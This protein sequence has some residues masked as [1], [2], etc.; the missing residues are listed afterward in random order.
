[1]AD[2]QAE[3]RARIILEVRS[4]RMT[5]E[6]G[7]KALGVSRKTFYQWEKKG[8][9]GLVDAVAN[10]TSGRPV[11]PVDQEKEILKKEVARL[12]QELCVARETLHVRRV[13]DAYEQQRNKEAL[14]KN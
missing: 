8:L 6:E 9:Q 5:A 4:G 12:K 1:M 14:K 2:H 13:L 7:A 3:E 11:E 10:G